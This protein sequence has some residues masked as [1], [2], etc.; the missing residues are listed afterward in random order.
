MTAAIFL[1]AFLGCLLA[2][3]MIVVALLQCAGFIVR[4]FMKRA[5][6]E[7][8]HATTGTAHTNDY[9]GADAHRELVEMMDKLR[10]A[11]KHTPHGVTPHLPTIA[12]VGCKI[13]VDVPYEIELIPHLEKLGW[14]FQLDRNGWLCQK[15]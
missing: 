14:K 2:F 1:A 15:C 9:L 6:P 8:I 12:C 5:M 7:V 10:E 4:R 13:S 3:V 11:A